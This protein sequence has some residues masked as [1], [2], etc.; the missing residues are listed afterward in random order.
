MF[1]R[2]VK[3]MFFLISLHKVCQSKDS[4]FDSV[5]IK[6][7]FGAEKTRVTSYFARCLIQTS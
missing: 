4:I 6:G 7:R 1:T 5:P 2:Q 3:M